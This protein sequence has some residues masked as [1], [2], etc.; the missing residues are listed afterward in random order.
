MMSASD[1]YLA[2]FLGSKGSARRATWDALAEG[3]RR[4]KEREGMAAPLQY[5]PGRFRRDHAGAAHT[6]SLERRRARA[7]D[8][9][10][11]GIGIDL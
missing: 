7:C 2:V 1:T 6:R 9:E 5:F 4:A 3:E 8:H 10:A 11:A